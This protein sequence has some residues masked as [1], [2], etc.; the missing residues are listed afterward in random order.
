MADFY[1]LVISAWWYL[2]AYKIQ[3]LGS[4]FVALTFFEYFYRYYLRP[5]RQRRIEVLKKRLLNLRKSRFKILLEMKD[6]TRD[7]LEHQVL[8]NNIEK[9]SHK[10]DSNNEVLTNQINTNNRVVITQINAEFEIVN[11]RMDDSDK[12]IE[13]ALTDIKGLKNDTEIIRT[14]KKYKYFVAASLASFVAVTNFEQIRDWIKG[15]LPWN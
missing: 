15:F 3:V 5:I 7:E 9:L 11:L 13:G 2:W 1:N 4:L 10:I 6:L 8:G 14:I 12:K